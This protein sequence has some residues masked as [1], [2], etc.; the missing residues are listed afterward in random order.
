MP[1]VHYIP[2]YRHSYYKKKFNLNLNE[3]PNTEKF[4]NNVV[5][6]PIYYNLSRLDQNKNYKFNKIVFKIIYFE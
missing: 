5:S 1:Q 3:F 4:Y 2:I 6:L